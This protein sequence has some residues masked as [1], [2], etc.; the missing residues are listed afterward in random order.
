MFKAR[1]ANGQY[2]ITVMLAI[3]ADFTG[4]NII[5]EIL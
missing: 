2:L 5:L 3:G 1:D 4:R